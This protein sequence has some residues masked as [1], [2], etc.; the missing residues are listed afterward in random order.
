MSKEAFRVL[1]R[2]VFDEDGNVTIC[3]REACK[4]LIHAAKQVTPIYGN[5]KTGMMQVD[6]IQ[7]LYKELFP[8]GDNV[9]KNN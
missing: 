9:A 6:A 4:E 7:A 1:F 3:G 8:D 2:E 5:E